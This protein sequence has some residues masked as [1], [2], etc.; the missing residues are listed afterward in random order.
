MERCEKRALPSHP[1]YPSAVYQPEKNVKTDQILIVGGYGVVGRRIAADLAPGYPDR[2]VLGGRTLTRAEELAAA[3][4]HGLRAR[5]IDTAWSIDATQRR[6]AIL[7]VCLANS[8]L[9]PSRGIVFSRRRRRVFDRQVMDQEDLFRRLA[10]ALA[11]GL[12]VGLERGWQLREE[13]EG[14]RT[15]GLRTYALTGLLGGISAAVS[16]VSS[17][18]VLAAALMSFT[19]AFTLF[20]WVEATTERNFSVTGVVAAILTFIIGAYAV[21]GEPLV[22]VAAA[23]A[24]AILLALKAPLHAWLRQLAWTELR[25]VLILLAMTFLLLPILPNRPIDPWQAINPAEIW[26]LAILIAG[27]SFA[28]YVA[29]RIMGDQTGIAVTAI[30]GGITSSTAT[31]LSLARLAR[32]QPQASSLLAAGILIAGITMIVRVVLIA[33]ALAPPL[34]T[35]L[36][37]PASAGA[38]ALLVASGVLILRD[39]QQ[40]GP[41]ATLRLTNPFDIGNA[42]KL[43]VLIGVVM[44]LAKVASSEANAKGLLLLAALSGIAD[45]DAITL[46]MARMAGATVPI[47]R[48][49][50]VIL[51]AVGVNTLAKAVMAAIVGGRK[52]GVTVGIPSLVAVV[53]LGLTR[54]L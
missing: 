49:V 38:I 42:V 50:D 30:A 43:A 51:I 46:S 12:L 23:V 9:P 8:L 28:G 24:M 20:A 2:V 27:V 25:A 34:L 4:G 1:E 39:R 52:I 53:L 47:P 22:A 5:K 35:E 36:W 15:A 31:T 32:E 19:A 3:I 6:L 44:V 48:A 17:P 21:L 45:V 29:T 13:A 14:E 18:L 40:T 10:V 37:L 41:A 26:L 54:L 33:T 16:A 11:V 7:H